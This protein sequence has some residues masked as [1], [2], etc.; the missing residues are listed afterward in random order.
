MRW[1]RWF[2]HHQLRAPG[3]LVLV[4]GRGRRRPRPRGLRTGVG[5]RQGERPDRNDSLAGNREAFATRRQHHQ[6]RTTPHERVC[7]VAAAPRTCSQLSRTRRSCRLL[8]LSTI[9]ER[10][11]PSPPGSAPMT[12]PTSG[13]TASEKSAVRGRRTRRHGGKPIAPRPRMERQTS[14]TG[15]PNSRERDNASGFDRLV[16]DA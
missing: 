14:L 15:T 11:S 13:P 16:D 7:H 5:T 3:C 1:P 6:L 8:R 10:R 2:R 4:T 9:A 12:S